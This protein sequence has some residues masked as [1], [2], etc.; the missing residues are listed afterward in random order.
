M[1]HTP[2]DAQNPPPLIDI[3]A[4]VS[5]LW[6]RRNLIIGATTALVL[7]AIVYLAVARPVYTAHAV[8]LIDPRGAHAT[9]SSSVLSGLGADSAAIA[10]QVAVIGSHEVLG[11]VFQS[12]GIATDPEF[13][14]SGMLS[15]VLGLLG[16]S[17]RQ[18]T[19]QE[20]YERFIS[21]VEVE[22]EGLT[23]ILDISFRSQ[24]P[25]KAA[26]IVNAIV[27][28]Y[29]GG[30]VTEKS[31]AN[32]AVSDLLEGRIDVLQQAVTEAEQAVET[33]KVAN[34]IFDSGAGGTM[35][36]AQIDQLNQ[37]LLAAREV[38]RQAASRYE[39]VAAA[40]LTPKALVDL[41][42]TTTSA[43]A[44]TLRDEYNRRSTE[45]ASAQAVMGAKHPTLIKLAAEVGRVEALM[46]REL[47]RL[48]LELRADRDLAE[49][50]VAKIDRDLAELRAESN[51]SNQRAVEL[52][53]L[54]RNAEASRQVLEQFLKRS[55]ET[56]QLQ[57]LQFSDA[58]VISSATP[59][60]QATW[61]RPGLLLSLSALLG[62]MIGGATA[63]FL[64]PPA[65]VPS[66]RRTNSPL[67]RVLPLARRRRVTPGVAPTVS[68]AAATAATAA[69][70][71]KSQVVQ[72]SPAVAPVHTAVAPPVAPAAPVLAV[73]RSRYRAPAA[74]PAPAE[75]DAAL[76]EVV[77]H[78]QSPFALQV[79]TLASRLLGTLAATKSP[80]VLLMSSPVSPFEKGRCGYNIAAALQRVGASVVVVDLDPLQTSR[81]GGG[82]GT[83]SLLQ[84]IEGR[85]ALPR[86]LA[87]SQQSGLPTIVDD[88]VTDF[89]AEQLNRMLA[90]L[91]RDFSFVVVIGRPTASRPCSAALAEL[92]DQEIVAMSQAEARAATRAPLGARR[93]LVV[94][95]H[96]TDEPRPRTEVARSHDVRTAISQ[97][98]S[99]SRYAELT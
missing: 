95:D 56:S 39:Q 76:R 13:S 67:R 6:Q 31:D 64:G 42:G 7:I 90:L 88:S 86:A 68:S 55:E 96:G 77:D 41:A 38:V 65:A 81:V 36:Q 61:P 85:V 59:P 22:R 28:R 50:N 69:P 93:A 27:E 46:I 8:V 40:G 97:L 9:D 51:L 70:R 25:Q 47:E 73:L 1:T 94:V 35:V 4:S 84:L 33:F 17:S 12:E 48:M 83:T 98:R 3:L 44:A 34:G 63:L 66:G 23:Y 99:R 20:V 74:A 24:D 45:H 79:A 16:L 26:R 14:G 62:L 91:A 52:R 5:I 72:A 19:E 18:A 32:A 30:Q 37:Q 78:P 92:A 54:E 21:Q 49:S 2:P 11:P 75:I 80:Y 10:S 89:D 43:T 71:P 53:Q 15:G 29:V 82:R 87:A 57:T 58:R 60:V